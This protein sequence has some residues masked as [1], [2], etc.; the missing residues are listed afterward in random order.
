ME[1]LGHDMSDL[2]ANSVLRLLRLK[3]IELLL[4][5]FKEQFL[6]IFIINSSIVKRLRSKAIYFLNIF[7][8]SEVMWAEAQGATCT[9]HADI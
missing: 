7:V 1:D 8:F 5:V 3:N 6:S 9:T 4:F 2:H